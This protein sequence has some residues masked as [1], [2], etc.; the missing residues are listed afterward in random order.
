MSAILGL[1]S[2]VSSA[3]GHTK[4]LSAVVPQMHSWTC[5]QVPAD[6]SLLPRLMNTIN[7]ETQKPLTDMQILA[8]A[9]TFL[10][11]G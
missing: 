6:Y 8:Q 4:P 9:N 3:T 7:K 5:L 2:L 10:L 11:A 1:L